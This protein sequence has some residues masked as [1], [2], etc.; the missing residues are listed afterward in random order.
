MEAFVRLVAVSRI[1]AKVLGY[2]F[3]VP[4]KLFVLEFPRAG[5]EDPGPC[6]DSAQ[7]IREPCLL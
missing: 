1:L 4:A 3:K 6:E 5:I 2:V 7:N